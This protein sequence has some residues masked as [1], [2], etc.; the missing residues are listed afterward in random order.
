MPLSCRKK[1]ARG[2]RRLRRR[3]AK[4]KM[5]CVALK[6]SPPSSEVARAH[7]TP[8]Y[9]LFRSTSSGSARTRLFKTKTSSIVIYAAASA[10]LSDTE[11][12]RE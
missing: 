11:E 3:R 6:S 4:C 1:R 12:L 8:L 9:I 10:L 7:G 5:A 2:S